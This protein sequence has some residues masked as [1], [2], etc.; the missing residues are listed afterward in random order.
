MSQNTQGD[1]EDLRSYVLP[2]MP[3]NLIPPEPVGGVLIIG[4]RCPCGGAFS[5]IY[6]GTW[7]DEKGST[8]S[9]CLKMLRQVGLDST[10]DPDAQQERFRKV[11]MSIRLKSEAPT[12]ERSS[13]ANP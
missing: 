12:D 11:C 1:N 6:E 10:P 3:L 13:K 5:D 4:R 7:T 2:D 9:V 8:V